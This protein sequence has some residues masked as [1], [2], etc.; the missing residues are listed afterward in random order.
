MNDDNWEITGSWV[1]KY[2]TFNIQHGNFFVVTDENALLD[3]IEAKLLKEEDK[4]G[5]A[6]E[7]LRSIGVKV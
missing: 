7:M 4:T 6:V 2:T 5:I 3:N 1:T